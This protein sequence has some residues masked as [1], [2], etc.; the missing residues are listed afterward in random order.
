MKLGTVA[1][2]VIVL[3]AGCGQHPQRASDSSP[4][5][6]AASAADTVGLA[7]LTRYVGQDPAR[8]SLWMT[9]PLQTRMRALLGDQFEAW[10]LNM[11][12]RTPVMMEDSVVYVAGRWQDPELGRPA[13]LLVDLRHDVLEVRLGLGEQ[14]KHFGENGSTVP[15]PR[16]ALTALGER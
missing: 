6:P 3:G 15:I 13:L 5:P 12:P 9:E 4:S 7:A 8:I 10:V 16:G 11:K 14:A 1:A 2:I